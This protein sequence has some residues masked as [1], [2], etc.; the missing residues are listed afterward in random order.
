MSI[1]LKQSAIIRSDLAASNPPD[2]APIKGTASEANPRSSASFTAFSTQRLIDVSLARQKSSIPA[3]WM[4]A[5]NGRF[6]AE[7]ATAWPSE[8]RP[9]F[10]TSL[11]GTVPAR[12][13]IAPLTPCGS[14][15]HHGIVF[16]FQGF[17]MASTS[18]A[19][20]SPSTIENRQ[21]KIQNPK[22]LQ[23]RLC[24]LDRP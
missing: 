17:T 20:K 9:N 13:L 16:R 1:D 4:I 18:C 6:P 23:S 7:V 11:N 8:S 12:F 19:S 21:S 24:D 10:A 2:P 5:L 14:N 3:T 15:S 22:S